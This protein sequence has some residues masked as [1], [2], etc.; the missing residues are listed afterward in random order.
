M[1]YFRLL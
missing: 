1:D